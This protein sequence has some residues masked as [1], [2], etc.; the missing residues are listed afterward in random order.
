MKTMHMILGAAL[1]AVAML[2]GGC[3]T[4]WYAERHPEKAH[5][6]QKVASVG[7]TN[8][9]YTSG[10]FVTSGGWEATARFPLWADE[11]WSNFGAETKADG[12]VQFG[13]KDYSR[14]LSANAVALTKVLC[15]AASDVT[16]KVCAAVVTQGGSVA[17]SKVS[18]LVSQFLARGG[19]AAKATVECKD[20]SCTVS[21]GS[22]TETCADC[23]VK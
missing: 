8:V 6:I 14:D 9:V 7:G 12:S 20:G 2:T 19:D 18:S 23:Y 11:K 15:D 16:A 22:V 13:V 17:A 1:V 3:Q 5:P 4:R 21:D 10:Y